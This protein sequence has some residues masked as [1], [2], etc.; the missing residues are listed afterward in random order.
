MQKSK[1]V[2]LDVREALKKKEDPFKKIMDAVATLEEGDQFILHAIFKPRPLLF[3]LGS[4]GFTHE[5]EKRAEDHWVVTFSKKK[6][7]FSFSK[8]FQSKKKELPET[9]PVYHMAD[10]QDDISQS[11]E[12]DLVQEGKVYHLDNRGLEP[13]KPMMRTLLQ[14]SRMKSG[15]Q[16]KIINERV[17]V[18]LFEELQQLGYDYSYDQKEENI[19]HITITK[20]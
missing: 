11:L 6:R 19:V 8:L 5:I 15:E 18:Y 3:V 7:K 4:K 16:L 20:R 17:P 13:P 12:K 2:E 14:L 9:P 10:E 1:I